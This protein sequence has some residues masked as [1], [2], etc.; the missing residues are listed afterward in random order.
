MRER[1][2]FFREFGIILYLLPPTLLLGW[3]IRHWG[4]QDNLHRVS[5]AIAFVVL[6]GLML[7]WREMNRLTQ[8]PRKRRSH[9]HDEPHR[10]PHH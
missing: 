8:R 9:H 6:S 10:D 4:G 1:R 5:Y 7:I 3:E 2:I